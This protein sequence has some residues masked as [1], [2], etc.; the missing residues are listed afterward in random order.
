MDTAILECLNIYLY[1][2]YF[3]WYTVRP[4][5][6]PPKVTRKTKLRDTLC[7]PE[8]SFRSTDFHVPENLIF[9]A[10]SDD[11]FLSIYQFVAEVTFI[12][13]FQIVLSI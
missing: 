4:A 8:L 1:I 12:S 2:T 7:S 6:V 3:I 11:T 13:E 10:L 5:H 9:P